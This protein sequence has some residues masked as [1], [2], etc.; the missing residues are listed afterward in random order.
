MKKI[1][2][3]ALGIICLYLITIILLTIGLP[4]LFTGI[5]GILLYIN[6]MA[7]CLTEE[8]KAWA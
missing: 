4:L 7:Y 2:N 1:I 5:L 3:G 8:K 6:F